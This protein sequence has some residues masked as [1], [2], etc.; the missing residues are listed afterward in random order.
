MFE[1]NQNAI[2]VGRLVRIRNAYKSIPGAIHHFGRVLRQPEA[3]AAPLYVIALHKSEPGEDATAAPKEFRQARWP[4]TND[5]ITVRF[6]RS[7]IE[8][9]DAEALAAETEPMAA[10]Q[11]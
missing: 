6:R 5:A 3:A 10:H 2:A 7:E 9:A 1:A 4:V 8:P 11:E